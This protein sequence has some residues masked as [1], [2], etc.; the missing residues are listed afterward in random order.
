V[1][2]E[3]NQ[4]LAE[5]LAAQQADEGLGRIAQSLELAVTPGKRRLAAGDRPDWVTFD[6]ARTE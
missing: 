5:I 3:L 2:D 1:L 4:L 6:A